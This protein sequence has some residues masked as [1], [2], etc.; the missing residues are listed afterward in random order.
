MLL[1][2]IYTNSPTLTTRLPHLS[3]ITH[4]TICCHANFAAFMITV[5][6]FDYLTYNIITFAF[7]VIFV[8]LRNHTNP[9][10]IQTQFYI[11][12]QIHYVAN[13][14][15]HKTKQI[16]GYYVAHQRWD[17]TYDITAELSANRLSFLGQLLCS[18]STENYIHFCLR[19]LY[20]VNDK[21]Y[22]YTFLHSV[23][24]IKLCIE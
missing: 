5:P 23:K 22:I 21:R 2:S 20:D 1:F 6:L 11:P 4:I 9:K 7:I 8:N 24:L 15:L 14:E 10:Y 16:S 3:C 17:S 18:G 12:L 19:D 13:L